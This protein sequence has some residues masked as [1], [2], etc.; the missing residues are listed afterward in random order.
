MVVGLEDDFEAL[1]ILGE[2]L[3]GGFVDGFV[4]ARAL[5]VGD[6]GLGLLEMADGFAGDEVEARGLELEVEVGGGEW[7]RRVQGMRGRFGIWDC[8]LG[9]PGVDAAEDLGDAALGEVV[10]FG[11][12]GLGE[13]FDLVVEIDLE[14]ARRGGGTAARRCDKGR[15]SHGIA[16][17]S[18]VVKRGVRSTAEFIHLYTIYDL[19]KK[20][21]GLQGSCGRNLVLGGSGWR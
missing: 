4:A 21:E 10:F 6:G 7:G 19:R 5:F 16:E 9:A 8:R 15:S 12:L 11:E 17:G 1:E 3:G 18:S 14:I 20:I 2:A 13:A